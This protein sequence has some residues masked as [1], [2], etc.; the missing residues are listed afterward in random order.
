MLAG[1]YDAVLA[2]L[3]R[4]GLPA[5]EVTNV[6]Q[7]KEYTGYCETCWDEWDV[8]EVTYT[9]VDGDTQKHTTSGD[10]GEFIREL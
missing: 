4:R 9:D 5:V 3:V 6:E 2:Y 8:V 7:G 1:F 10:M